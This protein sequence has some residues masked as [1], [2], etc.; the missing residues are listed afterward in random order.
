[1]YNYE[2]FV[3]ELVLVCAAVALGAVILAIAL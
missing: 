1:M 3:V 2:G